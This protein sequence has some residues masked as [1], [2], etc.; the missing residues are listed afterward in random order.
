MAKKSESTNEKI[1]R[2]FKEGKTFDEISEETTIAKDIIEGIVEKRIPDYKNYDPSKEV[3]T[4]FHKVKNGS[5]IA[6][7]FSG[8]KKVNTNMGKDGFISEQAR[9]IVDLLVKGKSYEDIASL[10]NVSTED[11]GTVDNLKGEH[12]NRVALCSEPTPEVAKEVKA[13]KKTKSSKKPAV[14]ASVK[15]EKIAETVP[16]SKEQVITDSPNIHSRAQDKINKF[17]ESQIKESEVRLSSCEEKLISF[18]ETADLLKGDIDE[19]SEK[20]SI[21]KGKLQELEELINKKKTDYTDAMA[22][23]SQL[24]LDRNSFIAEIADFKKMLV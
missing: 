24:E 19:N 2:L 15:T 21:L 6:K 5:P 11:I 12:L 17:V 20:V 7:L 22:M 1:I 18:K 8:K 3:E 16:E 14:S 4:K 10:L 13:G 23:I 9:A